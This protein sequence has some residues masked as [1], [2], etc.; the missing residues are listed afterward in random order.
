MD[1]LNV[2]AFRLACEQAIAS[3]ARNKHSQRVHDS[4]HGYHT[5]PFVHHVPPVRP[6]THPHQPHQHM[7]HGNVSTPWLGRLAPYVPEGNTERNTAAMEAE[8]AFGIDPREDRMRV[9]FIKAV[10]VA[11]S[12]VACILARLAMS[13]GLKPQLS[14][15][16]AVQRHDVLYEHNYFKNGNPNEDKFIFDNAGGCPLTPNEHGPRWCGG[17]QP[18]SVLNIASK[19]TVD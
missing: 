5:R 7:H 16:M 18:V 12:S 11:G 9:I 3:P 19:V 1:S 8:E 14:Y 15:R 10:K 2:T 13:H 17:F 4:R 6:V